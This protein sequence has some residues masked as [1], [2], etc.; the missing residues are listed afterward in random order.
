MSMT[1]PLWGLPDPD[2]HA[3]FY[4]DVAAKRFFAWLIDAVFIL[5]ITAI[6]VPFTAFTALFFLPAL[7][8]GV[9]LVYRT[10]SI[11]RHSATPGMRFVSI[12]FRNHRGETFDTA[13]ALLHTVGYLVS[14]SM[15]F[16]QV[17]SVILMLTS[18]RRQGLT[19]MLLGTAA[20]NRAARF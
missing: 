5:L 14:M 11:A 20:V 7:A 17:I 19:D 8:L 15:V 10:V 4:Q 12:E 1:E 9:S 6:I 2:T 16:P 18:R 3:E 13:T